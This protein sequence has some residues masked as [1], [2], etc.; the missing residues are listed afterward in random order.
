MGCHGP[1]AIGGG[2]VHDLRDA[3]AETLAQFDEIVLRGAREAL[4]M[5][6]FADRVSAA[7]ADS[8]EIYVR[9]RNRRRAP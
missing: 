9:S 1:Q 8:I 2:S 5:P 7:E 3:S 6:G 4:G